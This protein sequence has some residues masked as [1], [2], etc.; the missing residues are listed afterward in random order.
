[1]AVSFASNSRVP[2]RDRLARRF[3]QAADRGG[4]ERRYSSAT[5]VLP[6]PHRTWRE[7]GLRETRSLTTPDPAQLVQPDEQ[8]LL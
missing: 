7:V 5:A 1:M 6:A 4:P 3:P 8:D 2:P